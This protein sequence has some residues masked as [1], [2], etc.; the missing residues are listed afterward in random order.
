MIAIIIMGIG[1]GVEF[2]RGGGKG[3]G[4]GRGREEGKERERG[5]SE[6]EHT[7]LEHETSLLCCFRC[8]ACHTRAYFASPP[9]RAKYVS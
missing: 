7:D 1:F 2:G 4:A 8:F 3:R 5:G 6:E 9:Q